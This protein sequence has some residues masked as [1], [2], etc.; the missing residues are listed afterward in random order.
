MLDPVNR[1]KENRIVGSKARK[2]R[3]LY[4]GSRVSRY[5][6]TKVSASSRASVCSSEDILS[7]GSTAERRFSMPGEEGGR[8]AR[9]SG[10]GTLHCFIH[11]TIHAPGDRVVIIGPVHTVILLCYLYF[12][13]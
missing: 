2:V 6:R 3:V 10:L 4:S 11:H 9:D 7:A 8:R 12:F 13:Q 5:C 1:F